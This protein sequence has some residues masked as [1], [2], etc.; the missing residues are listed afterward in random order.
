[1]MKFKRSIW[2]YSIE[3]VMQ[4]LNERSMTFEARRQELERDWEDTTSAG[5]ELEQL[6]DRFQMQ[7]DQARER[8]Q[9]IEL[10]KPVLDLFLSQCQD[11]AANQVESLM[12]INEAQLTEMELKTA[13]INADQNKLKLFWQTLHS[14]LGDLLNTVELE[15]SCGKSLLNKYTSDLEARTINSD[16][17]SSRTVQHESRPDLY[18]LEIAKH[19]FQSENDRLRI[20]PYESQSDVDR[21]DATQHQPLPVF[22]A[23]K[24]TQHES[25]P[26]VDGF[27]ATQHDSPFVFDA[28]KAT[29]NDSQLA[30]EDTL[31]I[32]AENSSLLLVDSV[33]NVLEPEQALQAMAASPKQQALITDDDA[34]V[35]A[36][37][38]I[39][40]ERDGFSIIECTD[41]YQASQNIDRIDPPPLVILETNSP[42]VNGLEQV[43]KIRS[44]P[45]WDHCSIIM[46]T[47]T[48]SEHDIVDLLEAGA[49]DCI[50]K[51]VNTRELVARVRKLTGIEAVAL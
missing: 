31:Q 8:Q 5:Q 22:N 2:G 35:I 21:F 25:K 34:T 51:P 39:I 24:V 10:S 33:S 11:Y 14:I 3:Q 17:D 7:L 15:E 40:L 43:R 30:N 46:L 26:D 18:S 42:N 1:M 20:T 36:M 48:S 29:Q 4:S 6:L 45:A 38:R 27:D 28:F 13:Q 49:N 19:E 23:F 37:L 12:G 41:G 32:E 47:E 50:N 9:T 44:K 16:I